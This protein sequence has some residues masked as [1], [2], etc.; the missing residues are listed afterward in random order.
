MLSKPVIPGNADDIDPLFQSVVAYEIEIF[1]L[2]THDEHSMVPMFEQIC[3]GQ[4]AIHFTLDL[5]HYTY[6]LVRHICSLSLR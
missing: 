4:D 3:V 1:V 5:E 6:Q 2:S